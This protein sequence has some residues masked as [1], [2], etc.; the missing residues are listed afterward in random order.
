[1]G[2][3]QPFHHRAVILFVVEDREMSRDELRLLLLKRLRECDLVKE[4]IEVE[5]CDGEPGD[6]AD[7]M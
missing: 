6:P 3:H 7:L 4:T 1:M 5:E 2:N